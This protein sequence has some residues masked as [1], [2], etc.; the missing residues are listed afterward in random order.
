MWTATIVGTAT[1][2]PLASDSIGVTGSASAFFDT[3]SAG[4]GKPVTTIGVA[5][6]GSD[7]GKRA[8]VRP[9]GLSANV[10]V[11]PVSA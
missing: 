4:V 2:T 11:A 8:V 10:S 7:A 3:T 1:V 6:S 5:L 9:S